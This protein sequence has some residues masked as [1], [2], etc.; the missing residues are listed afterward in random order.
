MA[1][2]VIASI[3]NTM[4]TGVMVIAIIAA[5]PVIITITA[6]TVELIAATTGTTSLGIILIIVV[7]II[8]GRH[9]ALGHVGTIAGA[10]HIASPANGALTVMTTIVVGTAAILGILALTNGAIGAGGTGHSRLAMG[11][12]AIM[13]TLIL[14]AI[15]T[16]A[17]ISATPIALKTGLTDAVPAWFTRAASTAM[18]ASLSSTAHAAL[19]TGFGR[20]NCETQPI[21]KQMGAAHL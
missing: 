17:T 16:T 3:T 14:L 15:I 6:T 1:S 10:I 11:T 21:S 13:A 5:T 2:V 18:A 8:G 12:T 19:N 20:P 7:P 4:I 9:R